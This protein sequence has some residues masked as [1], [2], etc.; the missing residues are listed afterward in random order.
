MNDTATKTCSK[1]G[2]VKPLSDFAKNKSRPD[3]VQHHCKV[4]NKG[5]REI[6]REKN[7]AYLREYQAKNKETLRSKA[8]VYHAENKE[9]RNAKSRDYYASNKDRCSELGKAHRVANLAH[10][11]ARDKAYYEVNRARILEQKKEY[12]AKT[13]EAKS[14]YNKVYRGEN[15]DRLLENHKVYMKSRRAADCVFD[16]AVRVRGLIAVK[17]RT[18]G[19]TKKSS[20]QKILGCDWKFFKEHV[21]KQ[22]FGGMGWHNRREWHI[23]HIMPLATAKT[24]ED[25]IRLNHYSNLRPLWA[26][27]N[28]AKGAQITHLI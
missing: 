10:Y 13:G 5:Y 19:Y 14:E 8:I 6:D 7:I 9:V 24:E 23:D 27:D 16:L 15:W 3:G 12:A 4:C 11:T 20:A 22:F 26:K 17:I 28:L 2:E 18:A 25:V 21:E 1:C